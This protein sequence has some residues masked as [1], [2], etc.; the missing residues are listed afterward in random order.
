MKCEKESVIAGD[1]T[2]GHCLFVFVDKSPFSIHQVWLLPGER[3]FRSTPKGVQTAH[4][5][6]T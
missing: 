1:R 2:Q 6:F 5:M 3:C 4:N